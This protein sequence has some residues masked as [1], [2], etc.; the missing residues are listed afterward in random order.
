M[1]QRT[2]QSVSKAFQ[3]DNGRWISIFHFSKLKGRYTRGILLPEHASGAR[4]ASKAPRCV[5]AISWLYFI[6]RNRIFTPQNAPRYVT[7]QIFGT[8]LPGQIERT[9][10]APSCELTR[11]KWAWS[12]IREQNPLCVSALK[13]TSFLLD[14]VEYDLKNYAGNTLRWLGSALGDDRPQISLLEDSY[15]F[16]SFSFNFFFKNEIMYI[17]K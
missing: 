16:L 8:K 13:V 14:E 3:R 2:P 11:A 1:T 4:S 6:L 17:G 5:P 10:N 12:M 9:E 7:G 15:V